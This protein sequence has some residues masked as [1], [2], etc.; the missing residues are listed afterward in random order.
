M[1]KYTLY[2]GQDGVIWA[3]LEGDI[4]LTKINIEAESL[5]EALLN[6]DPQIFIEKKVAAPELIN[7]EE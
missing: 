6:H 5:E 1:K 3:A 7:Q 2:V 4:T